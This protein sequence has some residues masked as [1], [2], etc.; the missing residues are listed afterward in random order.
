MLSAL[1]RSSDFCAKRNFRLGMPAYGQLAGVTIWDDAGLD[2]FSFDGTT[3]S[4]PIGPGAF[5][6]DALITLEYVS[7]GNSPSRAP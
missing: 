6:D 5:S 1:F 2:E 4:V 3:Y 7:E